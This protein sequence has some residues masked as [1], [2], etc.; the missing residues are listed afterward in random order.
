MTRQTLTAAALSPLAGI[1]A[2]IRQAFR[3]LTTP[4]ASNPDLDA[5]QSELARIRA[6]SRHWLLG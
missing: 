3:A 1:E 5:L 4:T 2:S 6:T